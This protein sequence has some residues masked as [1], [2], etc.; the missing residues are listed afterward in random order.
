MQQYLLRFFSHQLCEPTLTITTRYISYKCKFR[1]R[2]IKLVK[3][4]LMVLFSFSYFCLVCEPLSSLAQT[5]Q[6]KSIKFEI[7]DQSLDSLKKENVSADILKKLEGLKKQP[8]TE[9]QGFLDALKKILGDK[10]GKD[11]QTLILKYSKKTLALLVKDVFGKS[12]NNQY[13][14]NT[15]AKLEITI[16]ATDLRA[17]EKIEIIFPT[18]LGELKGFDKDNNTSNIKI[19][20]DNKNKL[21]T[22]GLEGDTLEKTYVIVCYFYVKNLS[23]ANIT[24]ERFFGSTYN[25]NPEL[26]TISGT[27]E[28]SVVVS[29]VAT[30]LPN[31]A[32]QPNSPNPL[33][34][35]NPLNTLNLPSILDITPPPNLPNITNSLNLPNTTDIANTTDTLSTTNTSNTSDLT[36]GKNKSDRLLGIDT[37]SVLLDIEVRDDKGKVVTDLYKKDDFEIYLYKKDNKASFSIN[38]ECLYNLMIGGVPSTVLTNL[39]RLKDKV[40]NEEKAFLKALKENI[41]DKKMFEQSQTLILKYANNNLKKIDG[42]ELTKR[43]TLIGFVVDVSGSMASLLTNKDKNTDKTSVLDSAM[44][45]VKHAQKEDKFFVVDFDKESFIEQEVTNNI[46]EITNALTLLTT[47]RSQNL[48]GTA[49]ID[50]LILSLEYIEDKKDC[51]NQAKALILLSDGKETS[52]F[53]EEKKLQDSV[54]KYKDIKIYVIGFTSLLN[55]KSSLKKIIPSE[56]EKS[57]KFLHSIAENSGGMSVFPQLIEETE[58]KI[59]QIDDDLRTRYYLTYNDDSEEFKI[60]A[61]TIESLKTTNIPNDVV[62]KLAE[63]KK[64]SS[65]VGTNEFLDELEKKIGIEPLNEYRLDILKYTRV[66]QDV[67]VKFKNNKKKGKIL[68]KGNGDNNCK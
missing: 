65:Y 43:P 40:F 25:G 30:N 16:T 6:K 37:V 58:S 68:Y 4:L 11:L 39:E 47:R 64:D 46:E 3:Y 57:E 52:S 18:E 63:L 20:K 59:R 61:Q 23:Q 14:I 41:S 51:N 35:P 48:D 29:S 15:E 26:Y 21:V 32:P 38:Q 2:N 12:A 13:F 28:K 1:Q 42:F 53:Y 55:N 49:L 44:L 7:T 66:R 60:T 33:N 45:I 22:E 31:P 8:F 56:K 67:I 34:L 5:T 54:R 10:Q 62:S 50:T 17:G 27:K 19:D 24:V 9:E 36:V